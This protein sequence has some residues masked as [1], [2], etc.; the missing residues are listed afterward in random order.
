MYKHQVHKT[1]I[2]LIF[3]ISGA[4]IT[5][6][7]GGII[8]HNLGPESYGDYRVATILFAFLGQTLVLGLDSLAIK[9]LPQLIYEKKT[10]LAKFFL[11]I[12]VKITI[13]INLFWLLIS[14]IINLFAHK[15]THDLKMAGYIHPSFFYFGF[16]SIWVFYNLGIKILRSLGYDLT[17]VA[18]PQLL[19]VVIFLVITHI[20][21]LTFASAIW[22]LSISYMIITSCSFLLVLF[23]FKKIKSVKYT[24]PQNIFKDAFHYTSQQILSF[25]PSGILLIMVEAMPVPESHVGIL[26]V[27]F[28]IS[29]IV[30]IVP[31][32]IRSIFTTQISLASQVDNKVK[33]EALLRKIGFLS[34]FTILFMGSAVYYF[35]PLMLSIFGKDFASAA[36]DIPLGILA[37]IPG[38]ITLGEA[39]FARYHHRANTYLTYLS[40][41]KILF[42]IVSGF[43]LIHF[44][45]ITGAVYTYI[46]VESIAAILV[47]LIKNH[48]LYNYQ[49]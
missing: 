37:C 41:I 44:W 21:H 42:I 24:L 25:P 5:M 10:S 30:W 38:T 16:A 26:S 47:I 9:Y 28:M 39:T 33:I 29:S 36:V 11:I 49:E 2:A 20:N 14:L 12:I 32:T 34:L 18:L 40:I 13:F 6:Y 45:G 43:I 48:A 35:A 46:F 7:V 27:V 31:T 22:A 1:A 17:N 19:P 4:F 23:S 15:L 3:A 8:G